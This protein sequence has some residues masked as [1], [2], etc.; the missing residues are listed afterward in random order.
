MTQQTFRQYLDTTLSRISSTYDR[1]TIWMTQPEDIEG[2]AARI[3][4]M[5]LIFGGMVMI[6]TTTCFL[7]YFTALFVQWITGS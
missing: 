6:T 3:A 4:A 5:G 2:V 1:W 7:I